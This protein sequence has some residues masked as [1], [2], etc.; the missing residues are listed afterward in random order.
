MLLADLGAEVVRVDRPG[1]NVDGWGSNPVIDRSRRHV[2]ADLKTREGVSTVLGL[3]AEADVLIEGFRPGVTERL[4]LGPAECLA[5]NPR[6]VYGRMTGWGQDG[7]YAHTAGHDLTYLAVTGALHAIGRPEE[8]VPPLNV[9]GDFGGGGLLLAFGILAAA[10][11]AQRTGHGQVVDAAIVDGVAALTGMMHGWLAQG[12]WVDRRGS[13]LLDGGAPF[14]DTYRC[15]DG[16]HVAVGCLEAKFFRAMVERLGLSTDPSLDGNHLDRSRWPAIRERLAH[17][18]EQRTRD[19]WH[20]LFKGTD[21]CVA[22]V[23]SFAEAADDEHLR[24][25]GTFVEIDGIV[26]PAP[27]PRFG[28]APGQDAVAADAPDVDS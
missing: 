16:N 5:R 9:V 12:Q 23:L 17:A 8:P 18:F 27:V 13:N 14:Y 22:P 15:A 1:G 11:D 25:R 20:E 7:P 2:E 24:A 21:C 19:E 4:G 28:P 6:L 26:Q 10:W 3:V